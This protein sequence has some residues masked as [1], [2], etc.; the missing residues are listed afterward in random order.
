[1]TLSS[2]EIERDARQI[3]LQ[4]VGTPS[5][6]KLKAGRALVVGAGRQGD[7]SALCGKH[8]PR[9]RILGDGL[10]GNL[11]DGRSLSGLARGLHLGGRRGA[12]GLGRCALCGGELGG[13]ALGGVPGVRGKC[14]GHVILRARQWRR[15]PETWTAKAKATRRPFGQTPVSF[16][17]TTRPASPNPVTLLYTARETEHNHARIFVIILLGRADA[18]R[19]RGAGVLAGHTHDSLERRD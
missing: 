9:A 11:G 8:T 16:S 15:G 13:C 12:F 5:Q 1:M 2:E 4:G 18:F 17:G 7:R 14:L 6:N 10:G 3:V 19:S